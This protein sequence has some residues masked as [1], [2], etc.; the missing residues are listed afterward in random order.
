MGGL[1]GCVSDTGV[2]LRVDSSSPTADANRLPGLFIA[3]DIRND[4][5]ISTFV[6]FVKIKPVINDL[7]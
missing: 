3:V 6:V 2:S 4:H 1:T 5:R 7:Q